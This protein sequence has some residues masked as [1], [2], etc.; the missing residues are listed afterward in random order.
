VIPF[1]VILGA[2]GSVP[3]QT[4]PWAFLKLD[5]RTL[6]FV[7]AIYLAFSVAFFGIT[8]ILAQRE[9]KARSDFR[10]VMFGGTLNVYRYCGHLKNKHEKPSAKFKLFLLAHL[11]FL[12]C[13]VVFVISAFT[14]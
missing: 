7:V 9:I 12:L 8:A 5:G 14:G 3:P 1:F 2:S 10:M 11:N 13:A 4:S 6:D